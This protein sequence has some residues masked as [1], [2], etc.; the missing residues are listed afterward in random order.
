MKQLKFM[1]IN[2][3]LIVTDT[4]PG[5][6]WR[7]DEILG[8]Y[9]GLSWMVSDGGLQYKL[10]TVRE[11]VKRYGNLIGFPFQLFINRKRI[12]NLIAW[13]QYYG[14]IYALYCMLFHV[15]KQN[16]CMIMTF[17]YRQRP[18]VLGYLQKIIAKKIVNSKYIDRILVF[19]NSE[20]DYYRQLFDITGNKFVSI[21]LGLEDLTEGIKKGDSKGYIL[22]AGRSNRDYDFL[23]HALADEKY[24]VKIVCDALSA[25]RIGNIQILDNV[26][27]ERFFQMI[28][29]CY[30]VVVALKDSEISSG[31][32]VILQAMQFGKPVIV[33][34]SKT[35]TD[36][37]TDGEEG[38]IIPKEKTKLME[39]IDLLFNDKNL[40]VRMCKKA[41]A[42]YERNFS[43]RSLGKQVADCF[44]KDMCEKNEN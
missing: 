23:I 39:R 38:F 26:Y 15:K 1:R 4:K 27:Y 42:C 20:K 8:E 29:D 32:L 40:Y 21:K 10:G 3:N 13:Q 35:V 19:S 2:E 36:Y 17:I 18:G 14:L 34:R 11:K 22:S 30:C 41:R 28:A 7:F 25:G 12:H 5:K 9:T 43:M 44:I 37:I 33:T 6:N 31:Q 24:Q 16:Y